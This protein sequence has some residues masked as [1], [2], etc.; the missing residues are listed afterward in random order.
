M[1]GYSLAWTPLLPW[2]L[3]AAAGF[4]ALLILGYGV[5][6][7]ARGTAWRLAAIAIVLAALADP[8]LVEERR[9]PQKDVAL[10]VKDVSASQ[11]IGDRANAADDTL[12]YLQQKL[13]TYSDLDV[14]TI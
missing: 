9:E 6:R 5:W 8:S 12:H 1:T 14:R 2:P 10:L 4:V 13:A 3:L 11:S 7:R